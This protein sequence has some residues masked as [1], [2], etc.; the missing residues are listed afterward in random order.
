M[1]LYLVKMM[2]VVSGEYF[3]KVGVTKYD[4][5]VDRFS[6]GKT[7]VVESNLPLRDILLKALSGEKYI[8]DHPYKVEVIHSVAYS[9]EGDAFIAEK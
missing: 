5:V 1:N 8:S 6:Y 9:L 7:K 2:D 3:F 4:N